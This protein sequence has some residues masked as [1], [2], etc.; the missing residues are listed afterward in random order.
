MS[1]LVILSV[2]TPVCLFRMEIWISFMQ[3]MVRKKNFTKRNYIFQNVLF[4][5]RSKTKKCGPAT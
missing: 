4:L 2:L 1:Q 5:H 3:K